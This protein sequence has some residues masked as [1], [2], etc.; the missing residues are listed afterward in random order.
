[1]TFPCSTVPAEERF[2]C[3]KCKFFNS[4]P[5][6]DRYSANEVKHNT[7]ETY[8]SLQGKSSQNFKSLRFF[9][10]FYRRINR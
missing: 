2:T 8:K 4:G 10:D 5:E 1:M 3:L 6:C 9:G 7:V